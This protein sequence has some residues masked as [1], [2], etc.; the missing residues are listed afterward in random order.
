[1]VLKTTSKV[2]RNSPVCVNAFGAKGG[3]LTLVSRIPERLVRRAF[4]LFFFL[5]FLEP[6]ARGEY[7]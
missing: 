5:C 6:G 7:N 3:T 1:M 2:Y 4:A